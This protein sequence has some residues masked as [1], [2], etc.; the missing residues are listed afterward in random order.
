M[1]RSILRRLT[2]APSPSASSAGV[3][4]C[5]TGD[6]HSL[7]GGVRT[8]SG[9]TGKDKILISSILSGLR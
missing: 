9:S 4:R 5:A 3:W 7:K 2:H 8:V 1:C 6:I